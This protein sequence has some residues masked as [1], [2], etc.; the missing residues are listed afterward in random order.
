MQLRD[1]ARAE[2]LKHCGE[3]DLSGASATG[4]RSADVTGTNA[5]L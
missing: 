4:E 1:R 5:P 2:V 3:P